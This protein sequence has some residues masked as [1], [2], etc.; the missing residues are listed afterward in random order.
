MEIRKTVPS[1]IPR[2]MEVYAYAREFM[3]KT[4]NPNQWAMKNWPPEALIRRDV[5]EGNSYVCVNESGAVIGTFYFVFGEDIEP[6]YRKIEDGA[7][8]DDSAYGV[9]HR[10]AADGSE[11]GIGRFCI[12]WALRQCGH[13]RIDTH[14]DNKVM[15][16]VLQK[17]GFTQCGIIYVVEDNDPR[18][19]YELRRGNDMEERSGV[20]FGCASCSKEPMG[21]IEIGR[22]IDKL[23]GYF[24]KNDMAAAGD[25]L[26][27]WRG[28][29]VALGDLRGELSICS[30]QMGYYRKTLER[31]PAME[32]VARGLAL[33]EELGIADQP[34]AATIFLNAATTQKAF[35]DAAGALP[36]YEKAKAV[37]DKHLAPDDTRFAGFWNNYALALA[38][39]GRY[40]EA[41]R[42][43][44]RA[45]AILQEKDD[46]SLDAAISFVNLADVYCACGR[47]EEAVACMDAAWELLTDPDVPENGYCAYVRSK[48]APSFTDFGFASKGKEL[49]KMA[50]AWY[51]RA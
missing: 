43:Y 46:G 38:D 19:A 25:L 7:W 33:I 1:D 27:Y 36:L 11:K 13:L 4:G 48:C 39:L 21:K 49:T 24:A 17:M 9:V 16:S 10:L 18:Y 31:E 28:E 8:L 50:E 3:V 26:R 5:Q 45:I 40:Q 29:A 23:E 34:A 47:E 37:Y 14:A 44:Q 12:D 20:Q 6:T 22:V 2:V 51:A 32:A 41:E 15:Q 42:A 30:E 35:G